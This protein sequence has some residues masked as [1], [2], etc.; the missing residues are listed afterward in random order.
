MTG[1]IIGCD[2]V[3]TVV[4]AGSATSRHKV[5]DRVFG[6]VHGGKFPEIGAAAEY[7]V[8][9]DEIAMSAPESWS[10]EDVATL[11]VPFLTAVAVSF[12]ATSLKTAG[13][14]SHGWR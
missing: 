1:S 12:P 6:V 11:G 8:I 13:R 3:G 7:C 5:G 2:F 14:D 4:K 9:A 10:N